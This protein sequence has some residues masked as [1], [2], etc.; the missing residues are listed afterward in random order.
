MNATPYILNPGWEWPI[1]LA[2]F[3]AGIASGTYAMM[4]LMHV[5]GDEGD[6]SVLD[7]LGFVPMPFMLITPILLTLDLGQPGRFLNLLFTSPAATERSGPI[8]FNLASPMSWG[9]WTMIV[10]APFTLVA[11]LESLRRVRGIR[12]PFVGALSRNVVWLGIGEIL[13][14]GT[15]AY[16]GVLL[17]VT[18]QGVW[19]DTWLMGG[20]FI[21]FSELSG[22]AVAAIVAGMV[23]SA[24]TARA[25][26][27]ALF[28]VAAVSGA[29][30]LLFLADLGV[31][32]SVSPG[33][34]AALGASLLV[35]PVFWVGAVGAAVIFP[36]VT[37]G[38]MRMRMWQSTD[39]LIL[40]GSVVLLG[41]LAFRYSTFFSAIAFTQ[42]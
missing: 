24:H 36:L 27:T 8:M 40:M 39:R 19:S 7:R 4:G 17:N 9:S 37:A 31:D 35:G 42:R 1:M 38:P 20:L 6:R 32:P 3:A 29:L 21:A 5:A 13:A 22:V 23:G 34:L 33:A 14:L 11:F 15:S 26:R 18:N 10:F 28:G 16:S 12:M 2:L 25:I 41:V 30:L